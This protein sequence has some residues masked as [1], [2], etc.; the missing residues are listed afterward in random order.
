MSPI[1]NSAVPAVDYTRCLT[2]TYGTRIARYTGEERVATFAIPHAEV[3]V[4][5]AA[6]RLKQDASPARFARERKEI[7]TAWGYRSSKPAS[8]I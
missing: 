4:A 6:A 1:P 2:Y 3:S 8:P 7:A 5:R